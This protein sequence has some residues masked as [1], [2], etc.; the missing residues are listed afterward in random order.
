MERTVLVAGYTWVDGQVRLRSWEGR[1]LGH[2]DLVGALSFRVEPGKWC[3]GLHDGDEVVACPDRAP[4]T[5]GTSCDACFARDAFRPC[6]T[7]DGFRCPRL[8]GPMLAWC[9]QQH[10]LYLA[11]FGDEEIK[12]GTASDARR[13]QRIV[14]QG[15]LAAARVAVAEGPRIKQMEARL[16]AAGFAETMRRSRKTVLLQGAMTEVHARSLVIEATHR[17]KDALPRED[18]VLLH[19]PIF[20]A[21]PELAV[22]SRSLPVHELALEEGRVVDGEVV[23][24]VGHLV[25]LRDPDG[26]FAL[27]VGALK[28]RRITWNPSG[29]RRRAAAQLGL[30]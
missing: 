10:H 29:P 8:S 15:P 26:T 28:G 7:C 27:D 20:V 18:H 23:G 13:N 16:V 5:R 3:T 17:L 22:R 6:M 14:E 24:A 19:A 25:F 9:R 2:T 4:A 11:C 21:Q 12:V 30:F 1:A